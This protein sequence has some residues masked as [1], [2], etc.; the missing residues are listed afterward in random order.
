MTDDADT[1]ALKLRKAKTDPEPLP[2]TR[3]AGRE[4]PGRRRKPKLPRPE[5]YNLLAIYAALSDKE[6]ADGHR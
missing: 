5:A 3:G 4:G 1:I 6:L 2:G